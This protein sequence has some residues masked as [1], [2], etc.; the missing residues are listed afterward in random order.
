MSG[1]GYQVPRS[2][3]VRGWAQCLDCPWGQEG[4]TAMASGARH[5]RAHGHAV[6]AEQTTR[7]TFNPRS[8]A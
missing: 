5:A 1:K 2:S 7:S 8:G 6:E 3:E 4:P